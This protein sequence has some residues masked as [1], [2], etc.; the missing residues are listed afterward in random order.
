MRKVET[1]K[2]L[3]LA[4][5]VTSN[6]DLQDKVLLDIGYQVFAPSVGSSSICGFGERQDFSLFCLPFTHHGKVGEPFNHFTEGE[7]VKGK[8][9]RVGRLRDAQTIFM[10]YSD[11]S[12]APLEDW[13]LYYAESDVFILEDAT[14]GDWVTHPTAFEYTSLLPLFETSAPSS[15]SADGFATVNVSLKRNGQVIS[16]NGQIQAEQVSGYLPKTR[17]S[18]VN[19]VASFK[20]MALGLEAGDSARIKI[21]TKNITGLADVT[22]PV[23]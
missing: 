21:G 23:V 4:S 1:K 13:T 3:V 5:A 14:G 11:V 8:V 18:V 22:I 6:E 15:I 17:A 2:T 10:L 12:G 16:Y 7:S 20:V 19:G 9:T